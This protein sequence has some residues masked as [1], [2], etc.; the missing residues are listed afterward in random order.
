MFLNHYFFLKKNFEFEI[1]NWNWIF[2]SFSDLFQDDIFPPTAS[3]SGQPALDAKAW[4]GGSNAQPVTVDLEKGFVP[5]PKKEVKIEKV[6]IEEGPK[7]LPEF[8]TAYEA[9]KKRIAFLEAEMKKAGL[10]VPK[11]AADQ[12]IAK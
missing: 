11:S 6:E 12:V 7:T 10:T 4:F 8:K 1:E 5:P 2:E 9:Q 3:G